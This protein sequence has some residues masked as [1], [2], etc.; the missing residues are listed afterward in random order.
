MPRGKVVPVGVVG[1][2][3]VV[4]GSVTVKVVVAEVAPAVTV[5]VWA[6]TVA[7]AGMMI[8]PEKL[9]SAPVWVIPLSVSAVVSNV[10]IIAELAA[11]SEPLIA[12]LVPGGPDSGE[13]AFSVGVTV[14]PVTVK[15]AVFTVVLTVTEM[16]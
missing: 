15:V 5:I 6:P 13:R 2:G 8:V 10:T 1:G 11:K 7:S 16:V 9:P 3:V 4:E 12:M 14:V